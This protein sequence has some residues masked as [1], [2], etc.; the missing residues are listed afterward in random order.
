M[1]IKECRMC[2]SKNLYKFLDLGMHPPS[3]A[4][5]KKEQLTL[6]EPK[7]PL[8]VFLCNNCGLVQLG[9]VVDPKLMFNKEYVYVTSVSKTHDK[10]FEQLAKE[11][12]E[13]FDPRDGLVIDIGGND[14]TLLKHFKKFGC[15]VLNVDPSGVA[16]LAIK[17]GIDTINDFF[18][19]KIALKILKEKGKARI[20][21]ATNVFAHIHDLDDVLRG[22]N[23]LLEDDGIFIIESPYLVDLIENIEFD[24]IYHEHLSYLSIRPLSNF[25]ARFNMRIFD[26]K[27][28]PVHGGS[29]R[30]FVEKKNGKWSVTNA[31]PELIELEKRMGLNKIE[32]YREFAN[33]VEKLKV[34]L[35]TLLKELKNDGKMIVGNGAAAKGNT[36]LNYCQIG[37]DIIDYIVEINPIKQGL[38]TPG[39][40]I[41][42]VPPE[43]V[44]ED[45]PDYML[46]LPWNI[47]EDIMKQEQRVRRWGGKFIIPIP[48]PTI[49]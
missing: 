18:T 9:F 29:I 27:R 43:R 2:K 33:K 48:T 16:Q 21:T 22:V 25:F 17:S 32:T 49:V 6:P 37:P 45:K 1:R 14:G 28:T 34:D 31:A 30:V 40:H 20:I 10:H 11:A 5:L 44:N 12:V 36:L 4:F 35:V 39:M 24:T 19:E 23:L 46:I 8:D 38:Y 47:K 15:R 42:V 13:K 3:D 41:P 7:F 26:V